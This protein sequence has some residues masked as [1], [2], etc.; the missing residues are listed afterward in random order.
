MDKKGIALVELVTVLSVVVVLTAYAA[1]SYESWMRNYDVERSA[2]ELYSDLMHARL[3]A[4]QKSTEHFLKTDG[5]SYTIY[6]DRDE[7]GTPE[8]GEELPSFP[9]KVKCTLRSNVASSLSFSRRGMLS[10]PRTLW[11]DLEPGLDPDYDCMKISRTRIILGRY[12]GSE[13]RI[14]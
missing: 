11:F 5:T 13:C 8:P 9:K 7:D 14:D 2:K 1:F 4:M 6:E 10:L 12:K 3:M